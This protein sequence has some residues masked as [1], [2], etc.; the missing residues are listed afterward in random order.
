MHA[1]CGSRRGRSE[2]Q[3]G[4]VLRAVCLA[5]PLAAAG[6]MN[7]PPR[8]IDVPARADAAAH[9]ELDRAAIA[10]RAG[11]LAPGARV[12][13]AGL[14]RLSLFAA[15]LLHD[16]KVLEARRAIVTAQRES[17]S[18]RH[19]VTPALTLTSEYANDPTTRS[20]WLLGGA[21]DLPL[22]MGARRS[23]RLERA[24]LSIL[25]ARYDYAE[26]VWAERTALHNALADCFAAR[27]QI[28]LY[29]DLLAL[30]D[31]RLAALERRTEQG[32]DAR[33][34]VYPAR[35]DRA[36]A[37]RRL[38]EARAREVKGLTAVAGVL[39]VP[40]AAVRSFNPVWDDFAEPNAAAPAI[41]AQER[42][43]A[44]AARAD[45]LKAL[46]DYDAAE[47]DLRLEVAK[48]YP[49]V[50]LGP[51]Y[52]WER[53]LVKLPL[54][55]N[56]SLPPLDF[57]RS[58]IRAAMARRE[59]AGTAIE[60]RIAAAL[61]AIEA[62]VAE[63]KAAWDSLARIRTGELPQSEK[64]AE[65]AD[66]RLRLGGISRAEWADAKIAAIEARLAA[67]DAIVRVR[68]AETALE[69]ALRRP[70]DGP[71]TMIDPRRIGEDL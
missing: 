29:R 21:V 4:A 25:Q 36:S 51:G 64:L 41:G 69:D 47:A 60:T 61:N 70:L 3:R 52:T 44:S 54:A 10:A 26:T 57:N 15:L 19:S 23:S 31:R 17:A 48:Q 2:G 30:Q 11:R 6:C 20:P 40:E 37:A 55:V 34:L 65:R 7:V 45:V 56:L 9:A 28:P 27:A 38:E 62:A 43:G 8:P 71:E 1:P 42:S 59:Q 66:D 12:D 14:D 16:P 63:R 50:S 32:E 13:A 53:G 35:A 5:L 22:D 49:A 39:G 67:I 18:A 46:A 33:L 58:A 68:Q 24:D